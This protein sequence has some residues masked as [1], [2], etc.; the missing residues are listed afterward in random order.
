MTYKEEM[1][2]ALRVIEYYAD[3]ENWIIRH[4]DHWVNSSPKNRGDSELIYYAHP[5][6]DWT[7]NVTVGGKRARKFLSDIREVL[8]AHEVEK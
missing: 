3:P 7:G 4:K 5:N 6:T 1:E 8:G 2:K